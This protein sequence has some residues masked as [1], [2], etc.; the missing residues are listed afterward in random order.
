MSQLNPRIVREVGGE[1]CREFCMTLAS[2]HSVDERIDYLFYEAT[3]G[4]QEA[5][6]LLDLAQ[7]DIADTRTYRNL[8]RLRIDYRPPSTSTVYRIGFDRA[9]EVYDNA[10]IHKP[11]GILK[12]T[13][14]EM[15][16]D[17]TYHD[18]SNERRRF[19]NVAKA[20]RAF[21]VL[22]IILAL[23]LRFW[24]RIWKLL[25]VGGVLEGAHYLH[26]F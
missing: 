7:V 15:L 21:A 6:Y 24:R 11:G 22:H 5:L 4:N 17:Y 14:E 2:M 20:R 13:K 16:A 12:M 1:V 3:S 25:V 18:Y 26:V 19:G 10:A 8:T 9:A 23:L